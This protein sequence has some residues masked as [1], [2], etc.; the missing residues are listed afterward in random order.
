[1]QRS[2]LGD[3]MSSRLF[4][5]IREKRGLAYDVSS[6]VNRYADTGSAVVA[7]SVE[8]KKAV[9]T[10]GVILEQLEVAREPVPEAELVKAREYLKGRLQLRMEDTG[11]VASWIG[12]PDLIISSS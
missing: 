9:D 12:S 5:E 4:L 6:Y 1:M 2:V 10:I 7:A 8:P 3:G 11:A